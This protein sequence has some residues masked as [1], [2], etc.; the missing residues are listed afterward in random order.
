VT[1][2]DLESYLRGLGLAVEIIT[3]ADGSPYTAV[4]SF[5]VPAGALR[6]RVCD[7]AIRRETSVPYVPPPAINTRPHLVPM[8]G[9]EP[10]KTIASGIGPEWQYWSRRFDRAPTPQALWAHVLTVLCDDRWPSN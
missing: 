8:D 7:V 10:L 2:D 9:N 4:R 5:E 3:G 1:A 6:G